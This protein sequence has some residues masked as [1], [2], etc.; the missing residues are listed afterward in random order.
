MCLHRGLLSASPRRG[1]YHDGQFYDGFVRFETIDLEASGSVSSFRRYRSAAI[2][3]VR[4]HLHRRLL[5]EHFYEHYGA[6]FPAEFGAGRKTSSSVIRIR[7]EDLTNPRKNHEPYSRSAGRS[8]ELR[9]LR[10]RGRRLDVRTPRQHLGLL[11]PNGAGK[12]S[13]IRMIMN[14]TAPDTGEILVFG[15]PRTPDDLRRI[16]YLPEERGLYRK[17]TG[18]GPAPLPRRD[19]RHEARRAGA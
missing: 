7:S 10:G 12:T 16:G 17:M 15:R 2:W 6:E 8:E 11:G 1:L 9:Q 13:T 5:P 3:R 18:D 4:A 19:P 14:I